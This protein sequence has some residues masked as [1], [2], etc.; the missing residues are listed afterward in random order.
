MVCRAYQSRSSGFFT[1][2]MR[3]MWWYQGNCASVACTIVSSG[4]ASAKA[5][6]YLRFRPEKPV[7]LGKARP[8]SRAMRSIDLCAPAFPVLTL[9]DVSPDAPILNLL[10]TQA[11]FRLEIHHFYASK[12]AAHHWP[13]RGDESG[14]LRIL[15]KGLQEIG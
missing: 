11:M 15:E 2:S 7:M 5:R 12:K 3:A 10:Y 6:M 4:H 1:F 13:A 8:R 9:K 14:R